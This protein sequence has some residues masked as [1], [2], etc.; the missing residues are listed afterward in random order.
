M[1][2]YHARSNVCRSGVTYA[3]LTTRTFGLTVGGTNRL[4]DAQQ[5]ARFS[6]GKVLDGEMSLGMLLGGT[7]PDEGADVVMTLGGELLFGG[8]LQRVKTVEHGQLIEWD[9]LASDWWWLLNRYAHVTGRFIGGINTVVARI[10]ADYTDGGFQPG[11]LPSSLG[12]IDITFDDETVGAALKRLAKAAN[13]G[14]GAFLRLTPYKRVDIATSFPDGISLTLVNAT[15]A[16]SAVHERLLDQIRT[17]VQARGE[18]APTPELVP[19]GATAIPVAECGIFPASGSVWVPGFGEVAYTGRTVTS[20]P[21]SLTGVSALPTDIAQGTVIQ[22]MVTVNDATAQSDLATR[23]GGGRSGVA[24]HTI[25]GEGWSYAEA[26]ALAG[27]HLALLKNPQA[28]LVVTCE[29]AQA[30]SA[31]KLQQIEIGTIA[32]AN[33]TS[34]QTISGDF[35]LQR[36]TISPFSSLAESEPYFNVMYDARSTVGVDLF[37]L[38]GTLT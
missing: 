20:G 10:L 9:C 28:G 14:A 17:R 19:F 35:R 11:Y 2:P 3:G 37:D 12:D 34:P 4:N 24:L 5:K 15:N 1:P 29:A 18:G 38:L 36:V 16:R 6:I 33:V 27:A 23:L 13:N 25:A 32:A 8:T 7:R 22:L 31:G 21:G 30:M 26:A